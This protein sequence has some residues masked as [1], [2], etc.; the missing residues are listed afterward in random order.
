MDATQ[1][2]N[3]SLLESD[4]EES[5][6]NQASKGR[7]VAKLHILKNEH[8]L[9]TGERINVRV[10]VLEHHLSVTLCVV[11]FFPSLR[12]AALFGRECFGP[13]R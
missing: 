1:I 13:G 9:E 5:E 2:I 6:D 7:P 3:D 4:E 12:I 8:M 11:W 10:L